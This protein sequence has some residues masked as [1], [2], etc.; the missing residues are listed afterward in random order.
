MSLFSFDSL[1]GVLTAIYLLVAA[2]LALVSLTTFAVFLK[3]AEKRSIATSIS[4]IYSILFI[5]L[6]VISTS[7]L[8]SL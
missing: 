8:L 5:L 2:F 3:N 1:T 4:V 6:V 7:I